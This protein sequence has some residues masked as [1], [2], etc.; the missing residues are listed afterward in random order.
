MLNR[1][2]RHQPMIVLLFGVL[3]GLAY[4]GCNK[5]PQPVQVS[6]IATQD[7]VPLTS[8]KIVLTS[9]DGHP[10]AVGQIQPEGAFVLS[11]HQPHDGAIPGRYRINITTDVGQGDKKLRATFHPADDFVVTVEEGGENHLLI[12][13]S[14]DTG[15][16]TTTEE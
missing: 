12:D 4:C 10:P 11:T 9:R 13:V 14:Q 15:W 2:S 7:G 1:S 5:G 8:G 6:G 16:R 3:P